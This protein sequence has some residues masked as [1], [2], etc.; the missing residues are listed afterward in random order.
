VSYKLAYFQSS[1]MKPKI[2]PIIICLSFILL[3]VFPSFGQTTSWI[4]T[5]SAWAT[6]ANWTG[7]TPSAVK[8]VIIGDVNFTGS[9]QPAVTAAATAKSITFGTINASQL[10]I[11]NTL[12]VSGS[13]TISTIGT[14][15]SN[16]P[17]SLTGDW[18]NNG[19]FTPGTS[20]V[21]FNGT[22]VISGNSIQN[23]YD[24]EVTG[25][26]DLFNSGTVEIQDLHINSGSLLLH[27]AALQIAGTVNNAGTFDA[28]IGIIEMK[29]TT[30]Q[31]IPANAFL[32][33][34]VD[35]L[36]ISNTSV[37]GVTLDGA[38]DVYGSLTYSGASMLLTTNGYLTLKST[39]DYTAWIGNMTD[40]TITGEVT[41]ER[42]I[43][44]HKAWRFLSVPTNTT[45]T[46]NET[47]QEG[48][49]NTNDDPKPG[50]GIQITGPAGTGA[51]F[52]LYTSTPSMKKY[53]SVINSWAG[54]VNTDTG[55]IKASE[56]YMVFIRGDRTVNQ[57]NLPSTETVLRTKGNL[58]TGDQAPIV[59]SAGKFASIGNP[60]AAMLDMSHIIKSPGIKDF[61][62]VWDPQLGGTSGLGAYQTFVKNGADDYEITPGGG[63]YGDSGTVSNYIQSGQAFLVQADI[64][65]GS[66][67]FTE[68]AKTSGSSQVSRPTGLPQPKLRTTLYGVNADNS[69][70]M[71]DGVLSNYDDSY[72]NS[73][74]NMD[75][76]KLTNIS[77]N[78]SI[79]TANS[80][81]V[82]ERR[83][84]LMEKDTIFLNL[85]NTKVQKYR[86]EITADQLG[87]HGQIG[88]LEDT[89]LNTETPLNLNRSVIVDFNIENIPASYAADRFRILFKTSVVLPLRFTSIKA[90]Q[91]NN[92]I[93]VEWKT[94]NE[95]NVKQ[96]TVE[97]SYDGSY[98]T[99]A[100][101][102]AA[103][104]A[105]IN[106]Y[107]WTD[108]NPSEGYNYYRIISTDVN[109]KKEY[110]TVAKVY[111]GNGKQNIS[112][113]PNPV[114]NNTINLLLTNQPAGQYRIRL[115][116]KAGQVIMS[117]QIKHAKGSS[118]ETIE[119]DKHSAHGIYQLDLTTPD[120]K[121]RNI[122]VLL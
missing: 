36:L 102:V 81:L 47:W 104:D 122:E 9:N 44:D 113:S 46:V 89:Y 64:T 38:V 11:D 52:D 100:N 88:F 56:G 99:I 95:S 29:G 65:G 77:E 5:T 110:S 112:V 80:L 73:V 54:I 19:T 68:D 119:L 105:V 74:D 67:T 22:S 27:G 90:Y 114:V 55:S 28:G 85:A 23:F 3:K 10:T 48:A 82:A 106:T 24:L 7:G 83:H 109:G 43:G 86:F 118:T 92:D 37:E 91:E 101:A 4:G 79:K 49:I 66:L 117:K 30:T 26:L 34:T 12:T 1:S 75:A 121:T 50:Y 84:S 33:N 57:F 20:T 108:K 31:V 41:V 63:S 18:I 51:G 78:L 13:I 111:M 16:A 8:D 32:A 107:R 76:I 39:I 70:Y 6:P 15:T 58:Y 21:T 2:L 115:V 71:I 103:K 98:Y 45:Q 97:K 25:S 72:S 120:G 69:T 59:V 61:F 53:N 42:Y 17:I 87:Q 35:N 94:D 93:A 96:Y 62:Y 116:N 14:I 40:N 60:Y